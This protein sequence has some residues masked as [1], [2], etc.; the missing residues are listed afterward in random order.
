MARGPVKA[1]G[2]TSMLFDFEQMTP[3]QCF[4][5]LTGTVV[6]RPIALVTSVSPEGVVNAAPYSFFNIMGIEPP[7]VACTVLPAPDGR[8]KDTGQNIL[9][10]REFVANLVSESMAEAMNV[11]CID[12]PADVEELTLAGLQT[13]ASDALKTP[14]V[15]GCPV[16]LECVLHADI[17][18]GTNQFIAI[19]RIVRAHVA[20]EFVL[21]SAKHIFDTPGL[22]LIGAMH[23]AKWYARTSDRFAMERPTWAGWIEHKR[24]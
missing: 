8:M 3:M 17:P 18:L 16:A 7:V 11:T 14:R 15:A 9:S 6:P 22:R 5:F 1:L 13:V 19:G 20:D 4:E 24:I 23:A 10:A 12:A 21:D 2:V